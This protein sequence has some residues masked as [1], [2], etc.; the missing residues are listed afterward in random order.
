[1]NFR[2]HPKAEAEF[3]NAVDYYEEIRDRLGLE[4]AG[5]VGSAIE[6]IVSFP[7]AW[8]F[9][10]KSSRRCLVNRF[11]F[12]VVYMIRENEVVIL[13]VMHQSHKPNYWMDREKS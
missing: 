5:E 12:G 1:M 10:T 6:R 8:R 13:A 9:I 4:F 3:N 7:L 2:F 11:P